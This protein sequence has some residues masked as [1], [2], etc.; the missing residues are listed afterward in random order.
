TI[1]SYKW[2]KKSGPASFNIVNSNDAETEIKNLVEGVYEFELTVTDNSG[3]SANSTVKITVN[4][5]ANIPPTANAGTNKSITLPVNSVLLTGSGS[6]VDGTI[7][8]YKWTK[9]SGPTSFNI[10]NANSPS[11]NVSGLIQGVYEF[12]FTVTDNKGASAKSTVKVTVNPAA[13]IPPTANAGTD[14][15]ITL[16]TNNVTLSGI[17]T[18]EDG[19]ITSYKW[20]KISGPTSFNIVNSNAAETEIKNLVEG[21][22]EFEFTVTD[23]TSASANSTVKVTVNPAANIPPTANAGVNK[24]ITLPANSVLLSGSGSDADGTIVSY[25]WTKISGPTSFNIVNANSPSTDVS[26]LVQGI[27]EFEFTV[28]DNKG[29]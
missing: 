28:T 14:K 12:E 27:Y 7:T 17:G 16:P 21:V 11:T 3:A 5:A 20:I 2:T 13:N 6:D 1:S 18:D 29:A 19:T 23:N 15:S 24:S 10:V 4:P 22:Y 26:G 9:I 25:K 8:S